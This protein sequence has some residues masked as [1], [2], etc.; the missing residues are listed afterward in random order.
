MTKQY[1]KQ[2]KTLDHWRVS[3]TG[4]AALCLAVPTFI[5]QICVIKG[6]A[7]NYLLGIVWMKK[8]RPGSNVFMNWTKL[9]ES[10][11]NKHFKLPQK[12]KIYV[13]ERACENTS[14]GAKN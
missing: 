7:D 13:P 12:Q 10:F 6:T 11:P 1:Y 9:T 5:G 3:S 8:E 2:R 4:L 14:R